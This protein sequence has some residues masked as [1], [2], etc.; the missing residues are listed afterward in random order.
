MAMQP[1][2][3]APSPARAVW[4][5]RWA[6]VLQREDLAPESRELYRVA[7]LQYLRFCKESRQRATLDSARQ[8]MQQQEAKRRLDA[9]GLAEWKAALNW[10]FRAAKQPTAPATNKVAP[11]P[12]PAPFRR[13]GANAE[14]TATGLPTL[15]ATDLGRTEWERLLIRELRGRH[16][17]WRTEE[18]YRGWA[19]R[20]VRWLEGRGVTLEQAAET[21]LREYLSDLATRQRASASAQKQAL[22]ALV[23]LLREALGRT[24]GA[25]GDFHR[26]RKVTRVPVVLTR[27]ECRRLFAALEG[28]PRL[29]AELMYGSGLRLTELLGLRIHPV[30]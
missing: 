27:Q 19:W 26:A 21:E 28:V 13:P 22:N 2:S 16:Y 25:F 9:A 11:P 14:L 8:F 29:M 5:P 12:S 23:F 1:P 17:R 4:F 20:F 3:S 24:L 18:T 10:F 30:R 15:G 7:L 6:E